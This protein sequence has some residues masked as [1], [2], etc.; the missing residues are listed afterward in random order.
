MIIGLL[1][2]SAPSELWLQ[3]LAGDCPRH[4]VIPLYC[5]VS[6]I[7]RWWFMFPASFENFFLAMCRDIRDLALDSWIWVKRKLH[8]GCCWNSAMRDKW[9]DYM[10]QR[11][12]SLK[13][14]NN[15]YHKKA[16]LNSHQLEAR[17]SDSC[18]M[19]Q[20][21]IAVIAA[22]CCMQKWPVIPYN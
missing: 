4:C 9:N 6:S 7:L 18:A 8:A 13:R 21:V 15:L 16:T 19:K 12:G 2:S 20:P 5:S 11:L 3:E 10:S 14:S 22:R 17:I 1:S